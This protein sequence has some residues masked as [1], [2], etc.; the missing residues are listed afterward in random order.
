MTIGLKYPKPVKATYYA[1]MPLVLGM[2]ALASAEIAV[3]NATPVAC[4]EDSK[5]TTARAWRQNAKRVQA[6]GQKTPQTNETGKIVS[7][8]AAKMSGQ[9]GTLFLSRCGLHA[10]HGHRRNLSRYCRTKTVGLSLSRRRGQQYQSASNRGD[11]T[12]LQVEHY[13]PWSDLEGALGF[14]VVVGALQD[15]DVERN[16]RPLSEGLQHVFQHF[17]RHCP[18]H[19]PTR[20]Y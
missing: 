18:D 4:R 16:P 1:S 14:V 7:K 13:I 20:F 19:F 12:A 6:N 11:H 10:S 17:R 3:R 2:P 15:I 8:G 9:H 5:K